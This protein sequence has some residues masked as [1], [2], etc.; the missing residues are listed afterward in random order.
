MVVPASNL[1]TGEVKEADPWGSLDIQRGSLVSFWSVE[2]SASEKQGGQH[3]VKNDTWGCPL[4]FTY[5]ITIMHAHPAHMNMQNVHTHEKTKQKRKICRWLPLYENNIEAPHQELCDAVM[6]LVLSFEVR[7]QYSPHPPH[8]KAFWNIPHCFHLRPCFLWVPTLVMLS[9][10]FAWTHTLMECGDL[11]KCP[12]FRDRA[13][14]TLSPSVTSACLAVFIT[15]ISCLLHSFHHNRKRARACTTSSD[16]FF[17]LKSGVS[18]HATEP[19]MFAFL[20]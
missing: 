2:D 1:S 10:T 12:C 11:L 20:I 8:F 6:G 14:I 17:C 3:F 19:G 9:S 18:P 15:P 7:T 16:F 4:A 13:T 5:M